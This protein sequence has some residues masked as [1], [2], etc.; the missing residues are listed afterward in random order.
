M[1]GLERFSQ[2]QRQRW[3]GGRRLRA[4]RHQ[5]QRL[6][7]WPPMLVLVLAVLVARP[8]TLLLAVLLAV[9]VLVAVLEF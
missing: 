9:L 8:P 3:H 2:R 4:L 7:L 5:R 6:P 1:Q